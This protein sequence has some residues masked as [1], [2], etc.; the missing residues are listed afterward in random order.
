MATKEKQLEGIELKLSKQKSENFFHLAICNGLGYVC[1]GY[2]LDFK[3]KAD[4]YKLA[5]KTLSEKVKAGKANDWSGDKITKISDICF[6][7]V[8]MEMLRSNFKLTLKGNGETK[9]ITLSDV[10]NRVQKTPMNH[11]IEYI[12]ETGGDAITADVIIQTV[13]FDEVIY[14]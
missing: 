6:E 8:L 13:F 5:K 7:D 11:L 1:N 9:S 10:H 14:G 12:N 2:G 3:Y 4:E